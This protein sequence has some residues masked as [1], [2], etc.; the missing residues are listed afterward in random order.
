MEQNKPDNDA[1]LK[2]HLDKYGMSIFLQKYGTKED[3][4]RILQKFALV[5]YNE[6]CKKSQ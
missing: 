2:Q 5:Q 1:V 4:Q 6:L 3:I